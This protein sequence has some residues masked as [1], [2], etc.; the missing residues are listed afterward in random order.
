MND[1][2]II[3]NDVDD[4]SPFMHEQVLQGSKMVIE[5]IENGKWCHI[6]EIPRLIE[7][8][9]DYCMLNPYVESIT[10]RF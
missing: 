9:I 7:L 6:E 2:I 8:A 10:R 1:N 5:A 4:N 3:D